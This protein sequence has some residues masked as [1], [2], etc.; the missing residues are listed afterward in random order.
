[1]PKKPAPAPV[2][3]EPVVESNKKYSQIGVSVLPAIADLLTE[4][5]ELKSTTRSQ[6]CRQ[7][8]TEFARN[9]PKN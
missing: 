2:V 8:L 7:L 5:A 6:L 3:V 1:M 4:I 9:Y